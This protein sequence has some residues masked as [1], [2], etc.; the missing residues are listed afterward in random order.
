MSTHDPLELLTVEELAELLKV[1]KS[2]VYL[3]ASEGRLPS[4][5]LSHKSLRF[6]RCDV[7]E[8]LSSLR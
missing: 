2:W 8:Y 5:K 4:I 6:R 7:D 1:K 3:Q